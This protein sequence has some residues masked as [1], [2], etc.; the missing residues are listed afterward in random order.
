MTKDIKEKIVYL[1]SLGAI[2]QAFGWAKSHKCIRGGGWAV[3][4]IDLKNMSFDVMKNAIDKWEE[5]HMEEVH[6]D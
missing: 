6:G 1:Q 2:R 5:R 4:D 3:Y